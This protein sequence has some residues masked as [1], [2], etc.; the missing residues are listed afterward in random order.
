MV[1]LGLAWAGLGGYGLIGGGVM[2]KGNSVKGGMKAA[3]VAKGSSKGGK[4]G[5]PKNVK[6]RGK[7]EKGAKGEPGK[8]SNL[9]KSA[10][11]PGGKGKKG[12]KGSRH[13]QL[14]GVA[15]DP[16]DAAADDDSDVDESAAE[17]LKEYAGY[18]NFLLDMDVNKLKEPMKPTKP[19]GE[20]DAEATKPAG[21]AGPALESRREKKK[22]KAEQRDAAR[23]GGM[24][25][26]SDEELSEGEDEEAAYESR[27]RKAQKWE[28][29]KAEALPV[30]GAD[31]KWSVP[32]RPEPQPSDSADQSSDSAG[33][34]E[35]DELEEEMDDEAAEQAAAAAEQ[36]IRQKRRLAADPRLAEMARYQARQ[37]GIA[38]ARETIAKTCA[39]IVENPE[40]SG[41]RILALHEFYPDGDVEGRAT[42]PL[43]NCIVVKKML[44]LSQLAVYKDIV[45]GYKIRILSDEEQKLKVTKEVRAQRDYENMLLSMYQKFLQR[46]H[47][48][49][50]ALNKQKSTQAQLSLGVVAVKCLADLL[51]SLHHFNYSTNIVSTL[52]PMLDSPREEVVQVRF[53]MRPTHG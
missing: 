1:W 6:R 10:G 45:P 8:H 43:E 19:T 16:L 32:D 28:Q 25:K 21:P 39:A 51:Q 24:D 9:G 2:A 30:R 13:K 31:G 35:D 40:E 23:A 18:S 26:G 7:P 27:P 53:T 48:V 4:A 50:S 47:A 14:S 44:L 3:K 36:R 34:S 49:A 5:K 42:A 22:R 38:E 11:V 46:L 20:P 52:I 33:S 12:K 15:P 29:K 41:H 17:G 37:Q